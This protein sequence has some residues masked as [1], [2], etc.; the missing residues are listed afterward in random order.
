MN[1]LRIHLLDEAPRIGSGL[2]IVTALVGHKWVR[3]TDSVGNRAKLTKAVW[4]S[5]ARSG[6]ELPERKRRRRKS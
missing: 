1:R 3:I 5:I 6:V 2:R 4:A